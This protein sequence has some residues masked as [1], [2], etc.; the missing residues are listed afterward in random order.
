MQLV[1]IAPHIRAEMFKR[2]LEET[3]RECLRS[4]DDEM[5]DIAIANYRTFRDELKEQAA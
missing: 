2:Q 5:A 3:I 1:P 4:G